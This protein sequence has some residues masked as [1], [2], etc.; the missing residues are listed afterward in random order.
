MS[1]FMEKHSVSRLIGA[2]PGYVGYEEGGYLTEAVR[3]KPYSVILMDEVEKAH[4]DVF[5]VLLQ[6]L[7]DGRLTDSQ[8]R[9]VD[10]KN[11]VVVM[12]SN[13]GSAQIQELVGDPEAQRAAVM[14]A[15][16]HH[17]R[18]EFIN[19]I[20]E[21][22]VFDPLGKEQ[23]GGIAEIQL[24]RLRSRLAERELSLELT[25]EALEKLIAVGYDPVYGARPLKRAIQRWI[26]NPLAQQ[27]LAGEFA[28]GA[29]I[30][31][32]VEGEQIVFA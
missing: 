6:V 2:P 30:H 8:G 21:V 31:A 25:P 20:D 16:S 7:E 13:L 10:F 22:V 4:P 27:I 14:D 32:K 3:R 26:E 17:F 23:I 1:E 9:T 18:P 19:R 12:T 15:V 11:T 24:G 5:N 28:P 29:T